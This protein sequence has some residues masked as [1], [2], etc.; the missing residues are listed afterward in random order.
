MEKIFR[1]GAVNGSPAKWIAVSRYG[2]GE[3]EWLPF[4]RQNFRDIQLHVEGP[5]PFLR[6]EQSGRG[7]SGVFPMGLYEI[8]VLDL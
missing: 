5:H 3:R 4:T 8:Q 7:N 6:Q 2:V 1:N